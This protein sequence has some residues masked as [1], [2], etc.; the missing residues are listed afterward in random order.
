MTEGA[1]LYLLDEEF[2]R[3][4][5]VPVVLHAVRG[6]P[7]EAASADEW[8]RLLH[9]LGNLLAVASG[10]AEMLLAKATAT[11]PL[12]GDLR[13][14]HAAI[15]ESVNVFRQFVASRRFEASA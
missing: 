4:L 10:E 3:G 9:D 5:A 2:G 15:A 14:L 13:D 7:T 1:R 12:T 8:R 11:N 6:T